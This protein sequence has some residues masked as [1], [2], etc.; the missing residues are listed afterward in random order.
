M[1]NRSAPASPRTGSPEGAARHLPLARWLHWTIALLVLLMVVSGI[2]MKQIGSGAF[3]DF[4]FSAHKM[5]GLLVLAL[6]LLRLAYRIAARS[7]GIWARAS[8]AHP[9]HR[10]IYVLAIA[11]PLLG[12]AGISDFGALTVFFGW[13]L[14][15]IWPEG[16]G[17]SDLFLMAHAWLAFTLIAAVFVHVGVAMQDHILRGRAG[18]ESLSPAG[19]PAAS[20][21]VSGGA[22]SPATPARA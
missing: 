1:T 3:A 4:L 19:V 12:W 10:L 7:S 16:A 6:M 13:R 21:A 20:G 8:G 14:P 17:Q 22:A 5:S 15:A 11:V 2:L 9:A 18:E